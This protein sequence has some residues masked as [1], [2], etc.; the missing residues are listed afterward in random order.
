MRRDV[1]TVLTAAAVVGVLD[2]LAGG[3]RA[4]PL[5][6]L[7]L[8]ETGVAERRGQGLGHLVVDL[9][10]VE[11]RHGRPAADALDRCR[12]AARR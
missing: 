3:R 4:F 1:V 12:L 6:L 5:V 11:P 2:V 10:P 7:R 9:H 8:H